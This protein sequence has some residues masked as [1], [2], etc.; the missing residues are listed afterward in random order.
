MAHG[1]APCWCSNVIVPK[2]LLD[3]VPEKQKGKSCI[4]L[5]CITAFNENPT[6]F[7]EKV[8]TTPYQ[9]G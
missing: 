1:E 4:C 5:S 2:A 7:M 6:E 3:L 9:K 8:L